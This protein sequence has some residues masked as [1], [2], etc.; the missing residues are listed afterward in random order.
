MAVAVILLKSINIS[1]FHV[2]KCFELMPMLRDLL[3]IATSR[4]TSDTV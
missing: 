1:K 3:P 2:T 4:F